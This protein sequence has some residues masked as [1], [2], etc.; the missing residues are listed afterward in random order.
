MKAPCCRAR[1]KSA[2][3]S[4][5]FPRAGFASDAV[6]ANRPFVEIREGGRWQSDTSLR[7]YLDVVAVVAGQMAVELSSHL[8]LLIDVMTNFDRH[9]V[10]W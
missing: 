1:A 7:G 4:R 5:I 2:A 6:L 9:F 8:P 10:W 3:E